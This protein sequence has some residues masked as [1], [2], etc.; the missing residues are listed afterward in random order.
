[1]LQNLIYS[2]A[3]NEMPFT[4]AVTGPSYVLHSLNHWGLSGVTQLEWFRQGK[5]GSSNKHIKQ[6]HA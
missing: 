3:V 6:S 2:R 5:F 1:M 4:A